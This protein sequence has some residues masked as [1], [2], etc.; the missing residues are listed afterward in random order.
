MIHL[1][2]DGAGGCP[3]TTKY[4]GRGDEYSR[5]LAVG[6]LANW[7]HHAVT[8]YRLRSLASF[9]SGHVYHC[10]SG[11]P[12]SLICFA[13]A[14]QSNCRMGYYLRE[15][16]RVTVIRR[17][18]LGGDPKGDP[19]LRILDPRRKPRNRVT[20]SITLKMRIALASSCA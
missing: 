7:M 13:L 19:L 2:S 12:E 5:L 8:S 18:P 9:S 6:F 1:Q 11:D 17:D 10:V 16:I 3:L 20:D 4:R 15:G 14:T